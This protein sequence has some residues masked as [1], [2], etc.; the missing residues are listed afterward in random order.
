MEKELPDLRKALASHPKAKALWKDLTPIARRDFT[1]WI[2]SAKQDKTRVIRIEKTLSKLASGQKRPCCYA[3][4]PMSFYKALD[5][6]PKAKTTWK[7][8]SPD[9]RRDFIDWVEE[10]KDSEK[11]M[12]RTDKA[13]ML[14]AAGKKRPA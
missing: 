8:L 4:V 5:S 11:R 12:M 1:R 2:E 6:V 13:C 14:L 3:V 10:V 7:G 9:A